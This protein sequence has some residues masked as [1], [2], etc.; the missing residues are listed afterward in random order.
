MT[1]Y[2]QTVCLAQVTAA[3]EQQPYVRLAWFGSRDRQGHVARAGGPARGRRDGDTDQLSIKKNGTGPESCWDACRLVTVGL[4]GRAVSPG[5]RPPALSE[6][7]KVC[8]G[9]PREPCGAWRLS[10]LSVE[11]LLAAWHTSFKL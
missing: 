1:R 8:A 9:T 3:S 7:V 4:E 2:V 5:S 10:E 11:S 6:G